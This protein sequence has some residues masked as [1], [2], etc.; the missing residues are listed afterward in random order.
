M[1]WFVQ[2]ILFNNSECGYDECEEA[3]GSCVMHCVKFSDGS[4]CYF[5]VWWKRV[6]WL[7]VQR[8]IELRDGFA[9]GQYPAYTAREMAG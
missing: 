6:N 2:A 1:R 4:I 3:D 9:G 7:L 5:E 8:F